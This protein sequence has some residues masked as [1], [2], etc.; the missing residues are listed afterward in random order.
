MPAFTDDMFV[1]FDGD[2]LPPPVILGQLLD[3]LGLFDAPRQV[4]AE[5]VKAWLA[6]NEPTVN[7]RRSIEQSRLLEPPT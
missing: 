1:I 7:L 5:A 4:Q 2:P 3:R 6:D